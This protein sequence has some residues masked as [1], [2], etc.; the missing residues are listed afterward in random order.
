MVD[1]EKLR[2]ILSWLEYPK[3]HGV[4]YFPLNSLPRIFS[5]PRSGDA[6]RGYHRISDARRS[7]RFRPDFPSVSFCELVDLHRR[8]AEGDVA[9]GRLAVKNRPAGDL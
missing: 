7:P 9:I 5:L 3:Q 8:D 6:A 2:G 1:A 4:A